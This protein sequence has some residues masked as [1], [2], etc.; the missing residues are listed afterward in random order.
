[1]GRRLSQRAHPKHSCLAPRRSKDKTRKTEESGLP[2]AG[3]YRVGG[4]A[5]RGSSCCSEEGMRDPAEQTETLEAEHC[6]LSTRTAAHLV[7]TQKKAG[8]MLR[9]EDVMSTP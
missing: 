9:C 3:R 5:G 4:G 8:W 1:M 2:A 6:E 7:T